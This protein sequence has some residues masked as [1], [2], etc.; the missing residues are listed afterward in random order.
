MRDTK[1]ISLPPG[2]PTHLGT[3]TEGYEALCA[4]LDLTTRDRKL[5]IANARHVKKILKRT[6]NA[7]ARQARTAERTRQ[8]IL[9]LYSDPHIRRDIWC[10]LLRHDP[11][12]DDTDTHFPSLEHIALARYDVELL[13]AEPDSKRIAD[14]NGYFDS[15][16]VGD[17]WRAP[18]LAAIPHLVEDFTDWTSKSPGHR[19]EIIG[20]A[21]AT[22]TLLDDARLLLWASDIENDIAFEYSFLSEASGKSGTDDTTK[23]RTGSEA[24][25]SEMLRE[26]ALALLNAANDLADGP[27]ASSLFEVLTERYESV[28]ELKEKIL[29]R[30]DSDAID[31]LISAF[32]I[33][34]D[35]QVASAPWLAEENETLLSAWRVAYPT[36]DGIAPPARVQADIDRA[37]SVLPDCLATV[38]AAQNKED[39]AKRNLDQYEAGI[40]TKAAAS[41][42]D[43]QRQAKLSNALEAARQAVMDAM[44][45]LVDALMPDPDGDFMVVPP[46]TIDPATKGKLPS[47]TPQSSESAGTL[48]DSA[49]E[50]PLKGTEGYSAEEYPATTGSHPKQEPTV[51][52]APG[53]TTPAPNKKKPTSSIVRAEKIPSHTDD[54]VGVAEHKPEFVTD[55]ETL[56]PTQAAIWHAVGMD[57]T[58]LAYHIARLD[59]ATGGQAI[60]PPPELLASVALGTVLQGPDDGLAA[61]FGQRVG[62]LGGLDLDNVEQPLRDALNLLLF[63]A[64]LRPAMFA[65][66]HGASIP[67]LRRVVLSGNLAPVYRLAIAI[68]EQAEQLKGVHLDIQTLTAVIDEGVWKDSVDVHR[69]DVASWK[70]GAD[71]AT[72]LYSGAGAVWKH[73]LRR[74]GILGELFELLSD[75]RASNRRRVQE[76][77][78][79]LSDTKSVH[80]LI[81]YTYRNSVRQRGQ[82]ISGRALN[83]MEGR[84]KVP[85]E[86]AHAWLRIMD[87]RPGGEAF[88]ETAVAALRGVVDSHAPA[89]TEAIEKI[90][91]SRPTLALD[92]ALACAALAIESLRNLFRP[93]NE[94][95]PEIVMGPNEALADDLLWVTQLRIDALGAIHDAVAPED[96]LTQLIDIQSHADTLSAAFDERL[97][98]GDLVGASAVCK[99]MN[100]EDDDA[101]DACMEHLNR[102]LADS[103]ITIPRRL[104]DLAE[105]L[106]QAFLYGEIAEPQRADLTARIHSVTEHLETRDGTLTAGGDTD[107][108]AAAVNP[109]YDRAVAHIR[110]QLDEYLPRPDSREQ[111]IVEDALRAGDLAV[112]QEHLDCL[113]REQPLLASASGARSKLRD[114]LTVG[115]QFDAELQNES[116][117]SQHS[118]VQAV[119]QRVDIL[120]LPFS[121]LSQAQAKRSAALLELWYE[122]AH[123]PP[124]QP[125]AVTRLFDALGFTLTSSAVE[126]QGPTAAVLRAEPLRTRELCPTY[127]FGSE[128]DGRYDLLFNWKAPA[129]DRIIQA[130]ATAKP[131]SR[132]IVLHFGRLS[133]LDRDWLR[134]WSIEHP[135][136][137]VAVDEILVLY[138]ASLPEGQLRALFECT[139]PFTRTEPFFTA[140]GLVPPEAFFGRE[141]ERNDIM[142]RYGSC[143]VYG[144]RQLGKTALLHAAQAAFHDPG[145]HRLAKYIDL[146]YED[147]G[148]AHELDHLWLVLW[149]E[150]VKLEIVPAGTAMPR[151][152]TRLVESVRTSVSAWLN[153]HKRGRILLLLDEAD[154]FLSSDLKE[155]FPVSTQLKGLMDDSERR[156]KVVLC[157]LHNVL[158]NVERANHPLAHFGEPVCVG[159]LLTNGDIVQARALIREP[160]AAVGQ[161]FETDNL[162]TK[163]LIRTNYYPSLIQLY[164]EALLR[165][166]R[167]TPRRSVPCVVSTEDIDATYSRDQF[168]D[169]IRNRFSLTLQLDERYQVIAYAMAFDLQGQA[170]G[171][172]DGLS[173]DRI[174]QLAR[175]YWAEGFKIPKREFSTLLQEMEGLG[176]LR[177]CSNDTGPRRY[178]F[179]NPNVLRLLGDAST[180]LDVL[181]KER[182]LPD[183]FEASS[184]HSKYGDAKTGVQRY[185]PLTYEQETILGR[186]RRVA[187]VCGTRA[188]NLGDVEKYLAKRMEEDR[189]L[190]RPL[191]LSS[192]I[193]E[194][195]GAINRLRPDRDTYICMAHESEPWTLH[196]VQRVIEALRK[197]QRGGRLRVVFRADP[198]QLWR[199]LTDL[200]DEYTHADN[201]FFDWIPAQPWNA[202]FVRRWCSEEGVHDVDGRIPDLLELTGGWPFLLARF[203]ESEEKTWSN[204]TKEL[205]RYIEA[206]RDDLLDAV[207]LGAPAVLRELAP[208]R[209]WSRL[210]ADEVDTYADLWADDEHSSPV[211]ADVLRRRLWWATQL[212]IVQD[213]DGSAVFNSLITRILPN[214]A[215]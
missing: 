100:A 122:I 61:A 56:S 143:F 58:G 144:G 28:L 127:A 62:S 205:N 130:I 40:R 22:A 182:Q 199:V 151:G 198:E 75:E 161:E 135:T 95:R 167:Q 20:A 196:W 116:A 97:A 46:K 8:S 173:S 195:V 45:K 79:L 49:Q 70:E 91:H 137:F 90:R 138:L 81:E 193:N 4:L 76:I 200:P 181:L 107:E 86:L 18:A 65:S 125:E 55:A 83:Q 13:T 16:L 63:S 27:A 146:K 156:F 98:R 158:R 171:L 19:R 32:A 147:V 36:D 35:E 186:G 26:R 82:S 179:R 128:A 69:Q 160:L 102:N 142:D 123:Q 208:L 54:P 114:F 10:S 25:V 38:T 111:M 17:D 15:E 175:E 59:R 74:A 103:R 197:A 64:T 101:L 77:V 73:W 163:I 104:Y 155:D 194:L 178:V 67:L 84:L 34:L 177:Q 185:A 5:A 212:G 191:K 164:G 11:T 119:N 157:G 131:N 80:E 189:L 3:G 192:D 136:E 145:I 124:P 132:T 115:E 85:R 190:L 211:A 169:Y 168:R 210:N 170:D 113:K 24:G 159:P 209:A 120:G 23:R 183:V 187:V 152:R 51:R 203:A 109:P 30:A 60:Q 126:S 207:G 88:V 29:A 78:D 150:F 21:F 39:A 33:K 204:R 99:R 174:F 166:L 57:R 87:A 153:A 129:R 31:E 162:I 9:A 71:A 94:S 118:L 141:R 50:D 92:S 188:A 112:I 214:R 154:A 47:D 117:P 176:V 134:R 72:F 44:D 96:A 201:D 108:I 213:Q 1:S 66:Q 41:R 149:R 53:H 37:I 184:Y 6:G 110:A 2:L 133:A 165:H 215:T 43:R 93:G 172:I 105:R 180:I 52:S 121:D 12:T 42:A 89:A 140:P 106:E 14:L 68:A 148:V 202:A 48:L 7:P 139:L 206:H